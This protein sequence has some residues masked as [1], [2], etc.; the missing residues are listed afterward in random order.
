[1]GFFGFKG[2]RNMKKDN[3][4]PD[5]SHIFESSPVAKDKVKCIKVLGA[6]RDIDYEQYD[7]VKEAVWNV[8]IYAKV[9]YIN[10]KDKIR[11]YGIMNL[12]AVV[13]NDRV[14]SSGKTIDTAGLEHILNVLNQ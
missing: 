1:M 5:E 13:I 8:G 7:F 6:D 10:D 11:K 9:E 12:P 14:M 3:I 2:K 4:H